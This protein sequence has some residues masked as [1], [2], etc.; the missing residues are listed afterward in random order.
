[1]P[2]FPLPRTGRFVPAFAASALLMAVSACGG[3]A[4]GD[5]GAGGGADDG[6]RST[7]SVETAFGVVEVPAEPR[8]VVA[9]GDTSLDTA[10]YL[11][12]EP[13]GTSSARGADAAPGYLGEKAASVPLVATVNEPNIE[14]IL[15]AGPDLI[16]ASPRME[17]SQYEALKAVAPTVVPE[18]GDWKRP[19]ETYAEA[20]GEKEAFD[21]RIG[22]LL[23]RAAGAA[24]GKDPG[25]AVVVRWMPAGP[26]AMNAANMPSSLLKEAGAT[27]MPIAQELKSPHS[28]PLS[29]ENLGEIDADRVFVATLNAEGEKALEAA[30]EQKAFTR[31]KAVE[32]GAVSG[33]DGQVWS[34]SAGP[35]AMEKV[36]DDIEAAYGG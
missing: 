23:D 29:L 1:M 30:K 14:A 5:D 8:R 22:A 34:S 18:S 7:R 26:M 21:E 33:V 12:V 6:A 32:N 17:K 16:L 11:G 25:T 15:K 4:S 36:V 31:L 35:F 13:V 20:L 27:V 9:L 10:L 3:S 19:A 28:D 24:G 2:S